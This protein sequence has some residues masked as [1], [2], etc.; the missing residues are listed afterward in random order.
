VLLLA[1]NWFIVVLLPCPCLTPLRACC[2]ELQLNKCTGTVGCLTCELDENNKLYPKLKVRPSARCARLP[3]CLACIAFKFVCACTAGLVCLYQEHIRRAARR[4]H[5]PAARICAA[6]P[7]YCSRLPHA[8]AFPPS[9]EMTKQGATGA[10]LDVC[11]ADLCMDYD[12][13]Y[14]K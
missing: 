6:L 4:V 3:S 5:A 11:I 13:D 9:S 1:H 14:G 12:W 8:A 7:H 2:H 10:D